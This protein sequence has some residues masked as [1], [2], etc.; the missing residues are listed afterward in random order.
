MDG[1]CSVAMSMTELTCNQNGTIYHQQLDANG[2]EM[3]T[4]TFPKR[5]IDNYY[6]HRFD[7]A[8]H[9]SLSIPIMAA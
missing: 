8:H 3:C 6:A 4:C 5:N 1:I 2:N 7:W 9:F